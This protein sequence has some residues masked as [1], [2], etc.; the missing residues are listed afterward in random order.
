MS[1]S[2][3]LCGGRPGVY[4]SVLIT[5]V[6]SRDRYVE[7]DPPNKQEPFQNLDMKGFFGFLD[8]YSQSQPVNLFSV[9]RLAS[10]LGVSTVIKRPVSEDDRLS[11]WYIKQPRLV[12]LP[13]PCCMRSPYPCVRRCFM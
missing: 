8:G 4:H 1:E 10:C 9:D 11:E 12:Q 2:I 7:V 6:G 13:A 3:P 5:T